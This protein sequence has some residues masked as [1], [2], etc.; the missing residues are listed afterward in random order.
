MRFISRFGRSAAFAAALVTTASAAPAMGEEIDAAA[1]LADIEAIEA[2]LE[3][4][5]QGLDRLDAE[6]YTSAWTPDGAVVLYED[7]V[8]QGHEALAAY[9]A[10]ETEER[11]AAAARGEPFVQFHQFYNQR[12]EFTG[13]DTA[14]HRAY[15]TS[16][17]RDKDGEIDVG[18]IGRL[19]DTFVR[20]PDGSWLMSRREVFADP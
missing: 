11:E 19:T 20:Q 2:T 9:I 6:L 1:R 16:S 12:I 3:R 4:Y 14:E 10:F 18:F 13:P 7:E 17:R 5:V 8:H 15:W